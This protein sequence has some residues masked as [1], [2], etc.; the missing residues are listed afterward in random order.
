[1]QMRASMCLCA[2]SALGLPSCAGAVTKVQSYRRPVVASIKGYR[3]VGVRGARRQFR[4]CRVRQDKQGLPRDAPALSDSDASDD[5]G[6]ER[7]VENGSGPSLPPKLNKQTY[8]PPTLMEIA[9]EEAG[10]LVKKAARSLSSLPLAIAELAVIA[11]LSSVGTIIEQGKNYPDDPKILGFVDYDFILSTGY[12][13]VNN[14]LAALHARLN[15]RLK[16]S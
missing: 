11:A 4:V 6:A 8:V 7:S 16:R 15:T 5:D 10:T 14:K 2:P 9:Q 12:G 3:H 1:M 13:N